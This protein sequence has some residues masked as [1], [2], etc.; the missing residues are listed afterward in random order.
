MIK[1]FQTLISAI[2]V[3]FSFI[4]VI[5]FFYWLTTILYTLLGLALVTGAYFMH[6]NST[7]YTLSDISKQYLLWQKYRV[8]NIIKLIALTL[9][10][11]F[12]YNFYHL[13]FVISILYFW[14]ELQSAYLRR[15]R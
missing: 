8:L 7:A 1:F 12:N 15:I 11:I 4:D 3:Y 14:Y 13:L 6:T 2:V 5:P 10:L 9:V